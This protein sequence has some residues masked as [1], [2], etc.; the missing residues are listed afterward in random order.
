MT[1]PFATPPGL[2]FDTANGA[3]PPPRPMTDDEL[4]AELAKLDPPRKYYQNYQRTRGANAD[5]L[6]APQGL[7]ALFRA[8][9]HYKSGDGTQ[10]EA[11][12]LNAR[13][14]TDVAQTHTLY[15]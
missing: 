13:S 1:S 5:M 9:W 7:R 14:A 4:D 6:N 8:Y 10:K 3:A 2:P 12:P 15:G 11:P